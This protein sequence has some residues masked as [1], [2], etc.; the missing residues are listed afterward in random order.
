LVHWG[1]RP[2]LYRKSFLSVLLKTK[3]NKQHKIKRESE[4]LWFMGA[5]GP[6]LKKSF[7]SLVLQKKQRENKEPKI[8]RESENLW[9]MGAEGPPL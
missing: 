9:F 3:R 8:K 1:R 6:P 7:L 4:N 5:E 2:L